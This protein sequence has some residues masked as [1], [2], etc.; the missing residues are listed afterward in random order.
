MKALKIES[1][2]N[3]CDIIVLSSSLQSGFITNG[4]TP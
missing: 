3:H 2:L 4:K 1:K